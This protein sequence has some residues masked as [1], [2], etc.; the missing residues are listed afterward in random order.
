[1]SLPAENAQYSADPCIAVFTDLQRYLGE[2]PITAKYPHCTNLSAVYLEVYNRTL[3]FGVEHSIQIEM[4]EDQ[5]SFRSSGA[6]LEIQASR[7]AVYQAY[8]GG[9]S[10]ESALEANLLP[11]SVDSEATVAALELIPMLWKVSSTPTNVLIG[12]M[13]SYDRLCVAQTPSNLQ[14]VALRN[15]ADIM[16]H[17]LANEIGFLRETNVVKLW[18]L[19]PWGPIN[20]SLSDAILRVSGCIMAAQQR[21]DGVPPAGLRNWGL[22]VADAGF[23][24]K[25]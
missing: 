2:I 4:L 19:L 8:H 16:D 23:D 24:D 21:E 11:P 10:P 9:L 17:L 3:S 12:L 1:M 7:F 13:M 18:T 14:V 20:P 25:V 15:L 6:L 5:P 22:M